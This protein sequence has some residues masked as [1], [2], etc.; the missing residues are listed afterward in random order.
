[1]DRVLQTAKTGQALGSRRGYSRR[2][3]RE[4]AAF[5]LFT[6]PWLLGFLGLSL[7][8]LLLGLAA[9]FTNYDG[10]NLQRILAS[11]SPTRPD[12][13]SSPSPS[14]WSCRSCWRWP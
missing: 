7:V 2:E 5:H 3:R 14:A 6:L 1:M 8:P 12:T 10:L 13:P 4:I 9:S 11:H